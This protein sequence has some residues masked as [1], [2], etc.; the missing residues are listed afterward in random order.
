VP[1]L[2]EIGMINI[3]VVGDDIRYVEVLDRPDDPRPGAQ[4][5]TEQTER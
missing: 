4:S 2:P 5:S 3:D 1:L